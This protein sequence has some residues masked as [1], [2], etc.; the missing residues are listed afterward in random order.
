MEKIELRKIIP[1]IL[2]TIILF[3]IAAVSAEVNAGKSAQETFDAAMILFF[4][5]VSIPAMNMLR[6]NI[7]AHPDHVESYSALAMGVAMGFMDPFYE[8]SRDEVYDLIAKAE[9]LGPDNKWNHIAKVILYLTDYVKGDLSAIRKAEKEAKTAEKLEPSAGEPA[10]LLWAMNKFFFGNR[11]TA[12]K[13]YEKTVRNGMRYVNS[14]YLI[15]FTE[16][17]FGSCDSAV[18]DA[19]IGFKESPENMK[20]MFECTNEPDIG[21]RDIAL[22]N[23]YYWKGLKYQ[24]LGGTNEDI[25]AQL[26][27]AVEIC[28]NF[29]WAK[30][31]L[32][33]LLER[34]G[35][36]EEAAKIMS[37][38]PTA[39]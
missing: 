39:N 17:F 35:R 33:Q 28:P 36:T 24:K 14:H 32:A 1:A 21:P 2:I 20:K 27:K 23:C 12:K 8:G 19:L 22:S 25:E 37:T 5:G 30:R 15:F 7:A 18:E 10:F 6:E 13:Y 29:Y 26:R 38:I 34:T 31:F 16:S 4:Q 9:K 11:K 3:P